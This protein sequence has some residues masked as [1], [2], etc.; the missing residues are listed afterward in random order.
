MSDVAILSDIGCSGL[1]DIFFNTHALHGL[2][3]RALT[4]GA[5]IK[6]AQPHLKVVVVIG[7]A[8]GRVNTAGTL[9][10][11]AAMLAG[12]HVT[13]KNDYNITVMRGPSVTEVIVSPDAIT[14]AGVEHPDVVV[15]LSEEG[16]KRGWDL[17][18]KIKPDGR[19][20]LTTGV[21]IPATSAHILEVNFKAEGIKK[22]DRVLAALSL[23]AR[24]KD[25]V[26]SKMLEQAIRQSLREKSLE[27]AL[28]VL[29]KTAAISGFKII[30]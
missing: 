10:A 5:G 30:Q 17:F 2:H 28:H 25:P 14:F 15:A 16:V 20:I 12:M 18:G 11:H 3:G 19:L 29:E 23:L 27:Q 7:D 6:L 1:F 8:G 22:Q 13:Q 26:T 4:C 24:T 9:P 21:K